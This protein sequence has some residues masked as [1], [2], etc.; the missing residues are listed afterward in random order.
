MP[1]IKL[2]PSADSYIFS[3]GPTTNNGPTSPL[4][5]LGSSP[6][7]NGLLKF[8]LSAIP[9]NAMVSLATLYMFSSTSAA[10]DSD[11][12]H[13]LVRDWVESEVTWNEAETGTNWG[14]AGAKN[15]TT[16][17]NSSLIATITYPVSSGDTEAS[18]VVTSTIQNWVD[19]TNGNFG[20]RISTDS[21]NIQAWHSREATTKAFWPSLEITYTIPAITY[22][23]N[24]NV[25]T[26]GILADWPPLIVGRNTDS[27]PL[28]S[29]WYRHIWRIA[30]LD[31]ADWI[32]LKALRG[33]TLT[34][35]K[36]TDKDTSNVTKTYTTGRVTT[37]TGQQLGRRMIDAEIGYLVK[38]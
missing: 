15:T 7:S 16:D 21:V 8:D 27:T 25:I 20:F 12:L 17:Y 37:V 24:S 1:F 10:G 30:E 9:A 33:T 28:L 34:E 5:I 36:T 4:S 13:R 18:A 29:S 11:D 2:W 14:T 31:M 22:S 38:V 3:T 35:L 23:V 6:E 19:G 32:I 26:A